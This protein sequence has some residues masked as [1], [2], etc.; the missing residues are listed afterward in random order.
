METYNKPG[1]MADVVT[2]MGYEVAEADAHVLEA[3]INK[4]TAKVQFRDREI[5]V[6]F[7]A[8]KKLTKIV[9]TSPVAYVDPYYCSDGSEGG[10]GD[11][12]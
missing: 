5:I 6:P 2:F 1:V 11:N 7:H 9:E 4:K 8:V 3:F 12:L 10:G